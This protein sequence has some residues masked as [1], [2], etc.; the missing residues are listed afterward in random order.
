MFLSKLY[1]KQKYRGKGL[2][3][4]MLRFLFALA[5]KEGAGQRI[6]DGEPFQRAH[7]RRL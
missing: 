1:V 4:F 6:F 3:G 5:R 7:D 2:G